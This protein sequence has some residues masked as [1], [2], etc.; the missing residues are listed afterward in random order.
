MGRHPFAVIMRKA[1]IVGYVGPR[2][3]GKTLA[4]T[5]CAHYLARRRKVNVM[6]NYGIMLPHQKLDA[7]RLVD[8]GEDLQRCLMLIDEAHVLIDSRNSGKARNKMVSYF[9]TQTRKRDVVL[10]YTTQH[11]MQVDIRLRRATDYFVFCRR[12]GRHRFRY[13]VVDALNG[14]HLGTV[15]MDGRKSYAL[16][17]TYEAVTDFDSTLV[18][19]VAPPR[20]GR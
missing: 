10:C 7:A 11:V 19:Q 6:A 20:E 17:D 18:A 3:A 4:M 15:F 13:R 1:A 5:R 8:M 9:I 14:K 12:V 16:Y 2:G